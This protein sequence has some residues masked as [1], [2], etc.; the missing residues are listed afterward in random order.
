[1]TIDLKSAL[2][3]QKAD[4]KVRTDYFTDAADA[5]ERIAGPITGLKPGRTVIKI[6]P[7]RYAGA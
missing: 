6:D 4:A 3:A 2:P 1:M 7:R 5:A